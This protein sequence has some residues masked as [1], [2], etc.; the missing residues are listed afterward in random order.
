MMMISWKNHALE[1]LRSKGDPKTNDTPSTSKTNNKNVASKQ[2]STDKTL[3]KEKEKEITKE[4]VK[5]KQVTPSRTPIS[6]DLT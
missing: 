1:N 2:P 3:E 5:E 6:L 4:I